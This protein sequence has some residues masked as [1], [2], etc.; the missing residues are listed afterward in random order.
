MAGVAKVL[1]GMR[2]STLLFSVPAVAMVAI[3]I[4]GAAEPDSVR[5]FT[6]DDLDRM[7]GLAPAQPS[8]PVDKTRPEDW[9]WI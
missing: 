5:V 3:G 7:F 4:A 1:F 9:I 8:D 6:G 2:P